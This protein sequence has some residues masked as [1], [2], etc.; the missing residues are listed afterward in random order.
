MATQELAAALD[1]AEA[2]FT[3][4]PQ[5]GMHDDTPALVRWQGSS[6]MLCSNAAGVTVE[7][8][9]PAEMGGNG[10]RA[11]PGWLVR[12]GVAACSATSILMFA[13]REGVELD[14]LEVDTA[15][16]SDARGLLGMC[17]DDGAGI[18]PGPQGLTLLVRIAARGVPEERLRALVA[19]GNRRSPMF[20][21]LRDAIA[22]TVDVEIAG[23]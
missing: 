11:T 13:A 1:R 4:R 9:L 8:D 7:T 22:L 14:V 5:A 3:R 21:A 15:S 20:Y 17:G 12:A 2:V 16:R 18:Y 6:R 19:E 23:A 10:G